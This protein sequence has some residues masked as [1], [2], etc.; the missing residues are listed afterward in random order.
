MKQLAET[1]VDFSIEKEKMFFIDKWYM[2]GQRS[3]K[4]TDGVKQNAKGKSK[5][6]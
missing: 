6:R 1:I 2:H 3:V 4:L 5:A